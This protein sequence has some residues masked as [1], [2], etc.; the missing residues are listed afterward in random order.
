MKC[1]RIFHFLVK[2][3]RGIAITWDSVLSGLNTIFQNTVVNYVQL[4][5]YQ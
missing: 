3:F 2:R 1:F 5:P 4:K